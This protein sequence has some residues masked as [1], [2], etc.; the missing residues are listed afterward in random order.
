MPEYH[1]EGFKTV[2]A[3][4]NLLNTKKSQMMLHLWRMGSLFT[5]GWR[6]HWGKCNVGACVRLYHPSKTN[7]TAVDLWKILIQR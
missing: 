6:R 4:H 7:K 5:N 2:T 1:P 3:L